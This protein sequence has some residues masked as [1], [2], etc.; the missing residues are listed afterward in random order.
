MWDVFRPDTH[1]PCQSVLCENWI[2]WSEVIQQQ[3]FIFLFYPSTG[4]LPLFFHDSEL[5]PLRLSYIRPVHPSSACV[6]PL[7]FSSDLLA[8]NLLPSCHRYDFQDVP[9]A[10]P[11][12]LHLH[13]Q[14]PPLPTPTPFTNLQRDLVENIKKVWK[15]KVCEKRKLFCTS[16]WDHSEIILWLL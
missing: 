9:R 3:C 4:A 2:Y 1:T 15:L 13:P 12:R 16:Q 8:C 7:R 10:S 14:S 11:E 6:R 5:P